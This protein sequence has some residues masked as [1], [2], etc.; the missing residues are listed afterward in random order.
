MKQKIDIQIAADEV[1]CCSKHLEQLL[2]QKL[3]CNNTMAS[4]EQHNAEIG[5]LQLQKSEVE[6]RAFLEGKDPDTAAINRKITLLQEKTYVARA[7]ALAA[8]SAAN[9]LAKDIEIAESELDAARSSMTNVCAAV[10]KSAFDEAEIEYGKSGLLMKSAVVKMQ[11]AGILHQRI[12]GNP[13]L[14]LTAESIISCLGGNATGM[15]RNGI[16]VKTDRGYQVDNEIFA[17]LP[18]Q[19]QFALD[20]LSTEL[21]S[22]GA[23]L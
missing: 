3:R 15:L 9:L 7:V 10:T 8:K 22:Q 23:E 5:N 19:V 13:T 2:E 4:G 1:A 6:G 17:R 20:S 18:K 21:I 11:A 16:Q 14:T 12:T